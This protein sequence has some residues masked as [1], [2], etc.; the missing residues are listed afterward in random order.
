[1]LV[2][3]R[4]IEGYK[5]YSDGRYDS[6]ATVPGTAMTQLHID[7]AGQLLWLLTRGSPAESFIVS[8]AANEPWRIK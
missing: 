8:T 6:L 3:Q 5:L 1:M 2:R 4:D 7:I